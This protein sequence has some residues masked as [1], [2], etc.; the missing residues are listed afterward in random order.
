MF[1]GLFGNG[2]A[3]SIEV[4]AKEFIETDMEK[5][6]SRALMVK[7][8]DPNGLMRR[9]ISNK[10]SKLYIIYII[11]TMLL[12]ICQSFDIGNMEQIAVATNSLKDLFLPITG[13]FSSIVLA[14]FGVNG[15]NSYKGK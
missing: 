13:M 11:T 10:V 2:V 4:V 12:L 15:V 3:K 8:L 6:E 14:S 7:T 9:D 5:A 1:G